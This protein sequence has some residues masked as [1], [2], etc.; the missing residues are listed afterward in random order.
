[1]RLQKFL[2]RAGVASRRKCEGLILAGRVSVNGE[3][4]R[5]LGTVVDPERDRV[6]FDGVVR[7]IPDARV[8]LMLN[9]PAGYLTAM[10]DAR[11]R[12]VAELVPVSDFPG[13]F[14]VGR[15]DRDTTG[16]LLFTT[17]GELGNAL[18]HPSRHVDKRYVAVV[19]GVVGEDAVRA[20]ERGIVLEDGVTAPARCEILSRDRRR[21]R[22]TVALTIHEG[23][24]R[25]VKRMLASV[26]HEVC[27]LHRE[28][29]GPLRLGGL[30]EGKWRRLSASEIELLGA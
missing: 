28:S 12:T 4:V 5:E 29:F 27:S 21:D 25:Q 19:K 24:K 1:M 20:L 17:D 9:K 16:L 13:L 22:S 18:L 30:P 7:S 2:A 6:A 10:E 14:P 26:G 8:V 3:V 11:G 15:L 23:K